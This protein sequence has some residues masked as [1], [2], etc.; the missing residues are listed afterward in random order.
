LPDGEP[1]ADK[2]LE[3]NLEYSEKWPNVTAKSDPLPDADTFKA[4][5]GKF[6]KY[7]SSNPGQGD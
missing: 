5:D 1:E 6:D 2:W 7:F 3:L 4:E